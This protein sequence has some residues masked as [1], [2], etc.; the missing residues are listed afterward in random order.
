V[1]AREVGHADVA[2]LA[3]AH[4]V[5]E[6]RQRFLDRRAGVEAVQLEQVDVVG[7]QALQ[8]LVDA[9]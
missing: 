3:G 2:Q 7:A 6:R 1:P 5:V 4:Q 9:L 8:R